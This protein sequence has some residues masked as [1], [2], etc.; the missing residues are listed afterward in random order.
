[1]L[2]DLINSTHPAVLVAG[3]AAYVA[4]L[5]WLMAYDVERLRWRREFSGWQAILRDR[6]AKGAPPAPPILGS[7][8][9]ARRRWHRAYGCGWRSV[10]RHRIDRRRCATR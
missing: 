5:M 3:T 2:I 6:L 8:C 4:A 7:G 9:L 10:Q 1:M